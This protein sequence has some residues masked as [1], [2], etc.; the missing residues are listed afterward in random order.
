MS[1]AARE[2]LDHQAVPWLFAAALVTIAPHF[3]HQP[4]W[5]SAFAGLMLLWGGWLW[6]Q[7][8]RLPGRWL[9]L[10]LVIAGCAGI[11]AEDRKSVV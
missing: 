10:L 1:T 8:Q 5:L 2:A 3:E 11:Y 9:L 7:D 4:L 6:W